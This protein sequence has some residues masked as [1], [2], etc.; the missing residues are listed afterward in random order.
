MTALIAVLFGGGIFLLA[1]GVMQ[2]VAAARHAGP[3]LAY[4]RDAADGEVD[5]F[6]ARLRAPLSERLAA[7]VGGSHRPRSAPSSTGAS[8]S[9]ASKAAST[10]LSSTSAR[11][12]AP[13][14]SASRSP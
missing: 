3:S 1:V 2:S 8:C 12:S 9:P 6:R 11:P 14:R 5:E 13:L 10:R 7:G 4:L